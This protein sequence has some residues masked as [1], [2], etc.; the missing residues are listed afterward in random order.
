MSRKFV[1]LVAMLALLGVISAGCIG[2]RT[3]LLQEGFE[4][5]LAGWQIGSE[6]PTDPQTGLPV[7][8]SAELTTDRS[9][10]GARSLVMRIDG[11]QDD[12]TIWIQTSRVINRTGTVDFRLSFY[13]YS[14]QESFNVMAKVVGYVG[15]APPTGEQDFSVLGNADPAEGWNEFVLENDLNLEAGDYAWIAVGITVAWETFL[16]YELDDIA[17]TI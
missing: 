17:V 9:R 5:D 2:G 15:L 1:V 11:L 13:V 6:L 10:S 7:E 14:E 3:T 12:G 4:D 8:A 16:E